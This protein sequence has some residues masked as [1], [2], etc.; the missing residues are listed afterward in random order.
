MND[1]PFSPLGCSEIEVESDEQTEKDA[2]IARIRELE[3]EIERLK[4]AEPPTI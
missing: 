2:L 1:D 3:A 4:R